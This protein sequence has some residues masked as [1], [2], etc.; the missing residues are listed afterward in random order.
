LLNDKEEFR[1]K[2]VE[3]LE[4]LARQGVILTPSD[5]ST[6]LE[7]DDLIY[8]PVSVSYG[9]TLDQ[10]SDRGANAKLE[11]RTTGDIGDPGGPAR[12]IV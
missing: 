8:S 5:E 1:M 4:E 9:I 2:M 11:R 3:M 10:P 12:I 7:P 6:P